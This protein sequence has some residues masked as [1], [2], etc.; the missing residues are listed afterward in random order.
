MDW[1]I[2]PVVFMIE[3]AK[4]PR[5]NQGNIFTILKLLLLASFLA[6]IIASVNVTG[7]IMRARVNFT[8]VAKLPASWL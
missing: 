2:N 4:K 3:A 7:T 1:G 6:I 5:I 8:M